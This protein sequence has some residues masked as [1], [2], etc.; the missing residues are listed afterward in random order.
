MS[1]GN[2]DK[3]KV[4]VVEDDPMNLKLMKMLLSK[5]NFTTYTCPDAESALEMLKH[6]QPDVIL[7]DLGLPGM[8]GLELTEKLK[9]GIYNKIKII[10]LTAYA[11]D[12]DRERAMQA[13]CDGFITK[14]INVK[15]VIDD[16]RRSCRGAHG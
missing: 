14:P 12:I 7:M 5:N 9:S 2:V 1:M 15:Q 8:N 4:M 6:E 10:A 11:R 13:G 16:I 3:I